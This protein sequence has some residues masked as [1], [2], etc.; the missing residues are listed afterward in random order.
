M[1][2]RD[3]LLLERARLSD[4]GSDTAD[5]DAVDARI[6]RQIDE[7]IDRARAAPFPDA[8]EVATEF[9]GQDAT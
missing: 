1:R 5:L 4:L 7:M 3:P 9:K 8:G 6:A 2:E